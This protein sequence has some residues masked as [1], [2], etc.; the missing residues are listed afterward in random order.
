M[1]PLAMVMPD[2]IDVAAASPGADGAFT[3]RV[4]RRTE[5]W[6][7]GIALG[8][9]LGIVDSWQSYY[10]GK[11]VGVHLPWS[12]VLASNV[13]YW[14]VLAALVPPV[15]HLAGRIRLDRPVRIAAIPVHCLAGVVFGIVHVA[16]WVGLTAVLPMFSDHRARFVSTV[17]DYVAAEFLSYWAIVIAFYAVH[18]Y[19]EAQR[20]Q[21]AAAELQRTL[22]EA[23][24]EV[25]RSRM[26]PHFLFNTLNSISTLALKGDNEATVEMLA[27][28]SEL[29]RVSLDERCPHEVSLAREL[30]LLDRYLAIQRVRF[31]DRL[32][33]C[34]RIGDDT[35]DA[36]VPSMILQP[37]AENAI[38]HGIDAHCGAGT[39]TI[40]SERRNGA[41]QLRV[42][43][44]GPGFPTDAASVG[45]LGLGLS[46]TRARLEQLY[47]ADQQI[48][49]GRSEQGGGTVTVTLPFHTTP[50]PDHVGERR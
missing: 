29:L 20:R 47:G 12:R 50:G 15:F 11:A 26:N 10:L 46:N 18:Y 21:R 30:E 14:A 27:R 9:L 4:S 33:V 36:L 22:A 24:L 28:L 43:D 35:V 32:T 37:L 13:I 42:S 2:T 6:A 8:A 25:L 39:V 7:L 48:V 44:S 16:L 40:E 49:V 45:R 5:L 19:H 1:E 34:Q 23:R 3:P 38:R 31:A 41:L 17:R